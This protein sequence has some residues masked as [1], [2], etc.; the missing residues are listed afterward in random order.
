MPESTPAADDLASQI[1]ALIGHQGSGSPSAPADLFARATKKQL[2]D[3]AAALGMKGV[4]KLSR[5]DLAAARRE[6][7]ELPS[8]QEQLNLL[9]AP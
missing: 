5:E 4:S 3:C 8:A 9:P 6:P 1:L 2:L 7:A